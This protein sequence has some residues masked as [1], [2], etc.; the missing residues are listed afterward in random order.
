MRIVFDFETVLKDR[1]KVYIEGICHVLMRCD[2]QSESHP[3]IEEH[4][5]T[6]VSDSITGVEVMMTDSIREQLEDEA[7]SFI[8]AQINDAA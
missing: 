5:F 7:D 6:S 3:H 8:Y 2:C 1:R 4:E